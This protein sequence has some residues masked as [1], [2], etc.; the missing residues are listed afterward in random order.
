MRAQL[1]PSAFSSDPGECSETDPR[2]TISRKEQAMTGKLINLSLFVL[3]SL[4]LAGATAKIAFNSEQNYTVGTNPVWVVTG[5]FDNDG[6]RDIAVV[7]R[8]DASVGDPGGVS[9]LLGNGNGTF[10]PAK[11]IAIG[12]NCT[13][14][15]AGNFDG[16]G[17]DDLA[18]VRPGDASINDDGD[19]TIFLGNGDGTFRQGQVLTPG[20]NPSSGHFSI[21]AVDLNNDQLLD[22][23]VANSGD[24]TFSVML[25]NGNGTFQSPVVYSLSEQPE[26]IF[27]ADLAGNGG[28]DLIVFFV[29]AGQAWLTN[30]DGTFRAS[31]AFAGF[32]LLVGDFNRDKKADLVTRSMC[33][34]NCEHNY[35]VLAIGNGDG[36]FQPAINIGQFVSDAGDFDG[37]GKLDL[38]GTASA[39]QILPGNGDGT[40]QPPIV[41]SSNGTLAQVLDVN[42]DSAPDLLT[43]G[44]NS[45]GVLLNVGTDFSISASGPNPSTLSAGESATSSLTLKLL[46]NFNNPVSLTCA[47]QPAQPG[48]PT[49]SLS[50]SSVTFD[51]NGKA[52]ATLTISSG[53]SAASLNALQPFSGGSLPWLPVAGFFSLET[54]FVVAIARK[55]RFLML[56][57]GAVLFLGIIIQTACGGGGSSGGSKST[58]YTITV[59]AASGATQ[60]S[61]TVNLTVQ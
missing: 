19:V 3:L 18:L 4:K 16:D 47:V 21:A 43:V 39:I 38:A 30:G 2:S 37:D 13:G 42:G 35:P 20:K 52:S 33:I 46:S 60:H 10:Q 7:N 58:A 36:T 51:E 49:C 28:K 56:P 14:A 11:K 25:G 22:L 26:S 32:G 48:A 61:A 40:F 59:T 41:F 27:V 23:V 45:I 9:I 31:S 53:S 24:N 55:R 57:I 34:F 44:N 5:D 6:K 29:F 50:S 54:G 8:G 15:V 12:K 17:N 1:L